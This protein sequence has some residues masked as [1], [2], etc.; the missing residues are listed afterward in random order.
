MW[1]GASNPYIKAGVGEGRSLCVRERLRILIRK[2][3]PSPKAYSYI[4]LFIYLNIFGSPTLCCYERALVHIFCS[5]LRSIQRRSRYCVSF[6]VQRTIL[7]APRWNN[8]L[9]IKNHYGGLARPN[10][11]WNCM[12]NK[13]NPSRTHITTESSLVRDSEEKTYHQTHVIISERT[14]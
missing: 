6:S 7:A 1:S 4:V 10:G 14:Y 13:P 9:K 11:K 2:I 5:C 8:Q 12:G 3:L